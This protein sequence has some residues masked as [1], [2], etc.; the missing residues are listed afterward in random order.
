MKV[1][2]NQTI[3]YIYHLA[4]IHI[5]PL[6]RH[7]EYRQVFKNLNN[8]LIEQNDLNESI[9][10]I[11]G[12]LVHEKDKITPELIILLRDFLN[13]LSLIMPV[14]IFSGNHDLIENN[15]DRIANLDALTRDLNNIHYL[16]YT[17]LYEYGNIVFSLNSLEDTNY[18][19]VNPKND[20]IKIALYH[21]MLQEISFSKGGISVED[22]ENYDFVL[23]GD[24]H[25]RQFLKENIAYSG[26][27]I[28]QNFGEAIENHGLIKW[29][30]LNKKSECIDIPND[31]GY[32]TINNEIIP[33]LPKNSHIRLKLTEDIEIENILN[34]IRNKTNVLS[35]K[36]I[37]FKNE[38]DKIQYEEEFIENISDE[39]IIKEKVELT[40]YNKIIEL[41]NKIKD[42]CNF[43]DER[44][45]EYKWSIQNIE[46]KNLFI[47]GNNVLNKISLSDKSGVIG[48]LGKNA[49]GKSTIINIII[50]ALFDKIS[51]EYNSANIINKNSKN[52]YVKVEFTIGNTLYVIVKEGSLQKVKNGL[53]TKF[54][55]NY[56]KIENGNEINLNGKDKIKT[57]QLIEET[58][59]NRDM[60][61]LCNVSSY[62]NNLSIMDMSS[63]STIQTF[64]NLLSL[65][66]YEIL[67]KNISS[68]IKLLNEELIREESIY[69]LLKKYTQNDYDLLL[70]NISNKNKEKDK[71]KKKLKDKESN[72]E[73]NKIKLEINNKKIINIVKPNKTKEILLIDKK[74]ITE[75][76]KQFNNFIV[77]DTLES[78]YNNLYNSTENLEDIELKL[79]KCLKYEI[80]YS[81]DEYQKLK[82][83]SKLIEN[84][85]KQCNTNI[86]LYKNCEDCY[87]NIS[88][89][90]LIKKKNSCKLKFINEYKKINNVDQDK[91]IKLE[92]NIKQCEDILFFNC[93]KITNESKKLLLIL[94]NKTFYSETNKLFDTQETNN[95]IEQLINFF[96]KVKSTSELDDIRIQLQRDKLEYNNLNDII[97]KNIENK[98]FNLQIDKDKEYN[99]SITK[100][101]NYIEKSISHFK[102]NEINNKI[103]KLEKNVECLNKELK[104]MEGSINYFKLKNLYDKLVNNNLINKKIKFIK[105]TN[106]LNDINKELDDINNYENIILKNKEYEELKNKLE[107]E[108]LDDNF[109]IIKYK[110][111]LSKIET[112]LKYDIKYKND[113]EKELLNKK[114]SE[115]NICN[116]KEKLV[117]FNIYKKLVDKK[118]I[119]ALIL[120]KKLEFIQKDINLKLE[121]LVKFKIKMYIDSD[122]RFNLDIIKFNNTLKTYMCSGYERFILNIMIKN[123]LNRYCYNNK[124]NIFCIDEGL[125]CIDDD[126][127]NKFKIVLERL[128]RT[129]DHIILISQIDRI[130][131]YIDYKLNIEHKN[132]T[133]FIK[134]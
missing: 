94:K 9:I 104:K 63:L 111:D 37:K 61:K 14:L 133:S 107:K 22:F 20:K 88:Y 100:Q 16:K 23:L 43:N 26:S 74:S 101:L 128:Q 4:D 65:D 121:N 19:K 2:S 76:L 55:T 72:Y 85:L 134:V 75:E 21:G 1:L 124:S 91:M 81:E 56:F 114:N 102:F 12:D 99:E 83:Q 120:Q 97:N 34:E 84:E 52:M 127:L 49:I 13:N 126:N 123:S 15:S 69:S 68:K 18:F 73:E 66:K 33:D 40:N 108:L 64:S 30:I 95:I 131:K 50:F 48:V 47:Y 27:L 57:Q 17:D 96:D 105:L 6:D 79:K 38:T 122:S 11:C 53:K 39:Q 130:N 71:L 77:D 132:N 117:L 87:V 90:E 54:T 60:F 67:F 3:K 80:K 92:K 125:D 89:D 10:V 116:I 5:R 7:I 59:G 113:M 8:Y 46:F 106:N 29:D 42:E 70:K 93:N 36:V 129:Y 32:I 24:V 35:E 119:P 28:Q 98:K 41:H 110:E 45:S 78:L 44:I 112:E 109:N 86:K 51:S 103:K 118:C 115:I 25:E 82:L 62:N 58:I 31:V